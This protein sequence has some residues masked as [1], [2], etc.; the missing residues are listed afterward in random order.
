M[1]IYILYNIYYIYILYIYTIY[2]YIN[3]YIYIFVF[4]CIKSDSK[5]IN[6]TIFFNLQDMFQS[7]H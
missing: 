7:V 6:P 4:K 3:L 5:R 2:I 1:Y